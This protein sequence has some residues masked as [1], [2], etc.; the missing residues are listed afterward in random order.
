MKGEPGWPPLA[1]PPPTVSAS[2]PVKH[3]QEIFDTFYDI[4]SS[5]D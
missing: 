3:Q 1:S 5:S 2:E 4:E